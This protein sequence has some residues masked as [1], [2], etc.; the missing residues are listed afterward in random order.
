M[1]KF[2]VCSIFSL[3]V[4]VCLLVFYADT[5]SRVVYTYESLVMY[6]IIL[7]G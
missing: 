5:L 1:F 7:T 4:I 3:F 6:D 2:K